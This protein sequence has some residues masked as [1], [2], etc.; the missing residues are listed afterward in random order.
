VSDMRLFNSAGR[1]QKFGRECTSSSKPWSHK[2]LA[3][4]HGGSLD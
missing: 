1:K 2:T 3:E 4:I